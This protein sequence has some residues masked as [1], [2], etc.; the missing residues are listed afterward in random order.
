[1]ATLTPDQ[2][3]QR[4]ATRAANLA[5]KAAEAGATVQLIKIDKDAV[6]MD[7]VSLWVAKELVKGTPTEVKIEQGKDT[8]IVID[9]KYIKITF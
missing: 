5:Q 1:M 4:A 9:G 8:Y 7:N 6:F 2:K 3:A